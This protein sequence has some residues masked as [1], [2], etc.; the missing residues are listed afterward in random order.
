[1]FQ[2]FCCFNQWMLNQTEAGTVFLWSVWSTT[3]R[4]L[5][6]LPRWRRRRCIVWWTFKPLKTFG[7][8][9]Y[10]AGWAALGLIF[11]STNLISTQHEN[12]RVEVRPQHSG[13][14]NNRK[15]HQ[16]TLCQRVWSSPVNTPLPEFRS[17][18]L[19]H[20][21][22]FWFGFW[23][24]RLHSEEIQTAAPKS[25]LNWCKLDKLELSCLFPR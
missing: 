20:V 25:A 5:R 1:M 4:S 24:T 10:G 19:W 15:W 8:S 12:H 7:R 11:S 23:A 9:Q 13:W 2:A 22:R 18:S 3:S 6:L 17:F 21:T 14:V 16:R